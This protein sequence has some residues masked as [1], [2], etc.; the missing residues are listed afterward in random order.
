MKTRENRK[1]DHIKYALALPDG[2]LSNGFSQV[3][4]YFLCA[5]MS[6]VRKVICLWKGH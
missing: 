6:S 2:P 1:H 4:V 5:I 3:H